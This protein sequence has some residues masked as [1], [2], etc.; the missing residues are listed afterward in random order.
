MCGVKGCTCRGSLAAPTPASSRAPIT[1]HFG[2]SG[3][4]SGRPWLLLQQ[5]VRGVGAWDGDRVP[6]GAVVALGSAGS[7]RRSCCSRCR[8]C[9]APVLDPGGCHRSVCAPRDAACARGLLVEQHGRVREVDLGVPAMDDG[10]GREKSGVP[11]AFLSLRPSP[12]SASLHRQER[13]G[14]LLGDPR[15]RLHLLQRRALGRVLP[16]GRERGETAFIGRT[17]SCPAS[18]SPPSP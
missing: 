13:V 2:G 18:S 4:S 11:H 16:R 1:H 14:A 8:R 15:V 12:P 7:G 17:P 5:R 9:S 3:S 10:G 6:S